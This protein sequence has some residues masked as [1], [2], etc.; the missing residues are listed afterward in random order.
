[1]TLDLQRVVLAGAILGSVGCGPSTTSPD[2][3]APG[4]DAG[5]FALALQTRAIDAV[6]ILFVIDNSG[7]MRDNQVVL[8]SQLRALL[9]RLVNPPVDPVTLRPTAAPVR[10]L[11]VGVVSTDLG[12]PGSM[13]PSCASSDLGD[14]GLLNPIRNGRAVRQHQPWVTAPMFRPAR[15]TMDPNQYP[16]FLT[17]DATSDDPAGFREDFA[18]VAFLS[19]HGCGLE[20]P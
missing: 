17:F 14:D 8:T 20:Q 18:C 13:V 2:A 19:V 9:D 10:S 3:S 12:T 7:S 1:M 16:G 11:H 15:C 4:A 5:T 6:D